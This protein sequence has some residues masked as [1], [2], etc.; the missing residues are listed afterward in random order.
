MTWHGDQIEGRPEGDEK[1]KLLTKRETLVQEIKTL[2]AKQLRTK[3]NAEAQGRL[4]DLSALAKKIN[5][6]DKKLGRL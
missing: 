2:S 3:T 1:M 4:E 6:I 5:A